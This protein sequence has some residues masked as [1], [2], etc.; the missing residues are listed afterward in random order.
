M[1]EIEEREFIFKLA[2]ALKGSDEIEIRAFLAYLNGALNFEEEG[3]FQKLMSKAMHSTDVEK[4]F[5][6]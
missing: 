1:S 2:K 5:N 4:L 3:K 6:S